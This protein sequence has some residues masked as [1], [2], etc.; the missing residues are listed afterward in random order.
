MEKKFKKEINSLEAI[1]GF[2]DQFHRTHGLS[3][4]MVFRLN[5]VIEEIFTNFVK[6][7]TRSRKD[8]LVKLERKEGS[9]SVQITDFD[10][11]SF[12]ITKVQ[13]PEIQA[14]LGERKVGGLGLHLVRQFVETMEYEYRD[15]NSIVT[16]W[17][18]MEE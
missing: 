18:K 9:I 11:D 8:I 13:E 15:G 12:D 3:N 14:T 17:L 16:L 1:A 6:Y 7:N 4:S 5:I 2:V 10:V